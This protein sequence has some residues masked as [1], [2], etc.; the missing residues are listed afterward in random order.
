MPLRNADVGVGLAEHRLCTRLMRS[1]DEYKLAAD[2]GVGD[3]LPQCPTGQRL[4]K[5]DDV[6]LGIAGAYAEG[7]EDSRISRQ[8][9][10]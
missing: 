6:G 5:I 8:K 3:R 10:R 7:M 2:V 9:F 1:R 4:G